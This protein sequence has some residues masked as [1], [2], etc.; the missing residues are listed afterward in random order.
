MIL[1]IIFVPKYILTALPKL[2]LLLDITIIATII[3]NAKLSIVFLLINN[4]Q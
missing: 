2:F 1:R 3:I 4:K